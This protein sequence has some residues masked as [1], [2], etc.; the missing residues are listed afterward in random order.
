MPRVSN[1]RVGTDFIGIVRLI[2]EHSLFAGLSGLAWPVYTPSPSRSPS[3]EFMAS[4]LPS[5]L[6]QDLACAYAARLYG[7]PSCRPMNLSSLRVVWPLLLSS[8]SNQSLGLTDPATSNASRAVA[9][10]QACT[11]HSDVH[12]TQQRWLA[13]YSSRWRSSYIFVAPFLISHSALWV[14]QPALAPPPASH[15]WAEVTHCYFRSHLERIDRYTPMFLFHA[16]GSGVWLHTGRAYLADPSV[17]GAHRHALLHKTLVHG[18]GV[19]R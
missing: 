6:V 4:L 5:A 1:Q 9:V 13:R 8:A 16:P 7:E 3:H 14:H 19:G 2:V 17:I 15:Q 11:A 18:F 12:G 10:Y